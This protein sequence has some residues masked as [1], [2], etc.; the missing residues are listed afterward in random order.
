MPTT[1]SNTPPFAAVTVLAA[2]GSASPAPSVA[3][4]NTLTLHLPHEVAATV[5]GL[6]ADTLTLVLLELVRATTRLAHG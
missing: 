6:D 2:A 5:S 4:D 1:A 3:R